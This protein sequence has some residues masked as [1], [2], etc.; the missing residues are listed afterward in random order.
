MVRSKRRHIRISSSETISPIKRCA[1]PMMTFGSRKDPAVQY[2]IRTLT[3]LPKGSQGRNPDARPVSKPNQDSYPTAVTVATPA[4]R[5]LGIIERYPDGAWGISPCEDV[6]ET[7]IA[8]ALADAKAYLVN[9]LTE[10]VTV[11][12]NGESKQLRMV[13]E[14]FYPEHDWTSEPPFTYDI[15]FWDENHGLLPGEGSVHRTP[16]ESKPQVSICSRRYGHS[17]RKAKGL[18]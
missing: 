1:T 16:M 5:D 12:V 10:R 9:R 2:Y 15:E 17:G 6:R 3:Y 13:G 4:G 11:T 18:D 8:E 14:D 7:N